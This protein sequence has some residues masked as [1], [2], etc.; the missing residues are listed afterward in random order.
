MLD[1]DWCEALASLVGASKA[2]SNMTTL[3]LLVKWL[4]DEGCVRFLVVTY[5]LTVSR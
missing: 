1:S 4:N 2:L 3:N 5:T